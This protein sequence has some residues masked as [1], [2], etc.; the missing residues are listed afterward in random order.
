MLRIDEESDGCITSL[1][2]SGRI[3]S[4]GIAC[5]RSAMSGGCA[6]KVLDLSEVI[7][8]DLAGVQFLIGCEDEGVEL[9]GCPAWV[10]E[11]MIRE[12]AEGE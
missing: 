7:I 10:S 6:R 9:A 8:V 3:H 4:E 11:W 12:R 2:L 5:I 1:R